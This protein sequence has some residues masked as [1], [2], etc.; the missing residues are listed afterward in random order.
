MDLIPDLNKYDDIKKASHD[1]SLVIF[2][3]A[4]VSKLYGCPIWS[5]AAI[6]MLDQ[7][8]S[9]GIIN[10]YLYDNLKKEPSPKKIITIC[11]NLLAAEGKNIDYKSIYQPK[12]INKNCSVYNDL[13]RFKASYITTNYDSLFDDVVYKTSPPEAKLPTDD[14]QK[15]IE[16]KKHKIF[17]CVDDIQNPTDVYT[18][19]NLTHLHGSINPQTKMVMTPKE[20]FEHYRYNGKTAQILES[21]F[22]HTVLFIG[23]N[24]DEFEIMEYV[25]NKPPDK[26]LKS[27]L[28]YMTYKGQEQLLKAYRHYYQD[29]NIEIIPYDGTKRG[30]DQLQLIIDDW[31]RKLDPRNS[32]DDID[33]ID[34]NI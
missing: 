12:N 25:L 13:Y 7:L 26:S 29:L 2:I 1:G 21:L 14:K 5:E 10:H 28:L 32:L 23:Y 11:K 24:A 31:A 19:G 3:G 27:Y 18:S 34:K 20:Y 33:L 8:Y 30:Y 17:S 9:L 4:G 15:L 22:S 6:C 16:Q